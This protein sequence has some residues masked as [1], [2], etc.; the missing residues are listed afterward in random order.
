MLSIP[1]TLAVGDQAEGLLL[2]LTI[3]LAVAAVVTLGLQRLRLS[4][5]P[6]YLVAGAII[7]PG[8]LGW[9]DN[10]SSVGVISKLAIVMLMFGIGMHMDLGAIRGGMLRA[11]A[12]G[13]VSTFATTLV[14]APIGLAFGLSAPAS[15]A[16]SMALAM[17]STAAVLR[18]L[19]TRRELHQTHGR[20]ALGVLIAQDLMVVVVLMLIP[21]LEMWSEGGAVTRVRDGSLTLDVIRTVLLT[22]GSIGLIVL[23]GQAVLPRILD[24]A[25]HGAS[26]ELRLVIAG[27]AAIGSAAVTES[28]GFSAELGAFLAGFLLA[29]TNFKHEVAGQLAPIRDLFMAIF[30]V[31]VGLYVDFALLADV[32]WAVLIAIGAVLLVKAASIGLASWAFGASPPLA[33]RTGLVL[34]EA[35]EF[36]LVVAFAASEA[37]IISAQQWGVLIGIV[38]ATLMLTPTLFEFAGSI[39]SRAAHLPTAPWSAPRVAG[40]P[41][42]IKSLHDHVII[43]GFGPVGRAVAY[44]LDLAEVS[45]IVVDLNPQTITRQTKLGRRAIFGDVTNPEV[46]ETAGIRR[47]VAVAIT[48]PDDEA[49]LHACRAIRAVAPDVRIAARANIMSSALLA[50]EIGA[51][52]VTVGE[53]ATAEA[54]AIGLCAM[55][56]AKIPG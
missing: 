53:I 29:S 37:G 50:R 24:L 43:A 33:L 31:S 40:S 27:A 45:Y 56:G 18:I 8:L 9:V 46:L 44:R 10:E 3:V 54:M 42:E 47:A 22:V 16:I 7:G 32:W 19:Q 11:L 25:T 48:I 21:A 39:V 17:S 4:T 13:V 34:A 2:D 15:L 51:D 41:E 36:S 38:A 30:F 5:I 26:P 20:L 6:G 49:M 14:L 23:L 55:L 52:D 28:L 35:G 1:M 12:V